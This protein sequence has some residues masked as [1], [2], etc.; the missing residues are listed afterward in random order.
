M[1]VNQNANITGKD[2]TIYTKKKQNRYVP[3]NIWEFI[4]NSEI[5]M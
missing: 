2:I 1:I 5:R 3:L 4:I